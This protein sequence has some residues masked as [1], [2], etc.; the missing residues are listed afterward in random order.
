MTTTILP[1]AYEERLELAPC[2][3]VQDVGFLESSTAYLIETVSPLLWESVGMEII[4]P[5][6][7]VLRI[8]RREVELVRAG[9]DFEEAAILLRA[10]NHALNIDFVTGTV[11]GQPTCSYGEARLVLPGRPHSCTANGIVFSGESLS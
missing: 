2:Q 7:A 3:A 11:E 4:T 10:I 5:P 1:L 9:I 8:L 6:A